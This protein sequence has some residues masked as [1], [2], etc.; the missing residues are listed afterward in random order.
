MKYEG[1]FWTLLLCI[2]LGSSYAE[3][4]SVGTEFPTQGQAE[5]HGLCFSVVPY[6]QFLCSGGALLDIH[7]EDSNRTAKDMTEYFTI[8][9]FQSKTK[10]I[11]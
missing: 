2:F 11:L 4:S 9:S 7:T 1:N 10:G 6:G 5:N 3:E 8:F